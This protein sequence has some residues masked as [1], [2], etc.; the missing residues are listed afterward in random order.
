MGLDLT[1]LPMHGPQEMGE[2]SIL[3]YNLLKFD[4]DHDIFGQ[5]IELDDSE[6][7]IKPLAIPPQ[8][9]IKTYGDEGIEHTRTDKYGIE[10]TFVYAE[11]LKKLNLP[12]NVSAYNQAIKSFIDALP[13]DTPIILWWS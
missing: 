4:R 9:W 12:K 11:E 8:M 2:V 6:P 5:I 1:I 10:L 7:T 3:T 13:N